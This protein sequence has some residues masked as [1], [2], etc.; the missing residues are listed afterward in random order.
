MLGKKQ[1]NEELSSL[2]GLNFMEHCTFLESSTG[3]TSLVILRPMAAP[4][5]IEVGEMDIFNWTKQ[6]F[7][8][9]VKRIQKLMVS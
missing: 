6:I 9:R 7:K 2:T 8:E 3:K 1:G 5:S 4:S